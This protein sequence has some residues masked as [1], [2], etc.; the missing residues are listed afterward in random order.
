MGVP[1][2]DVHD[3]PIALSRSLAHPVS[4]GCT[5]RHRVAVHEQAGIETLPSP[6]DQVCQRLMI[7]LPA[8]ADPQFRLGEGQLAPVDR[9]TRG[10]DS[11]DRAQARADART[12]RVH[13]GR[14]HILEHRGIKLPR[15]A[16]R[17]AVGARKARGEQGRA[18]R[19]GGGEQLVHEAVLAAPER[20]R[21]EPG[22]GHEGG[23]VV[24]PGV[25]RCED[26]GRQLLHGQEQGIGRVGCSVGQGMVHA[27]FNLAASRLSRV[28]LVT[29]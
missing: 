13:P 4:W 5:A 9:L 10:H 14:Q 2:H 18:A 3:L 23:W 22:S 12:R 17:I 19:G 6:R 20:E 25:R 11:R 27:L 8:L 7:R 1:E 28:V 24:L 26:D 16:V 21:V 15:L 29:K